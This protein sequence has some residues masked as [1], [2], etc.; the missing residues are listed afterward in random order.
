MLEHRMIQFSYL[1]SNQITC[2]RDGL[3]G[4]FSVP[5][6]HEDVLVVHFEGSLAQKTLGWA[7]DTLQRLI[8]HGW[9][10]IVVDYSRV[11]FSGSGTGSLL[12]AIKKARASGGGLLIAAPHPRIRET[13]EMLGLVAWGFVTESVDDAVKMLSRTA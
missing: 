1:R 12:S 10:R 13:L 5:L 11:T 8:E 4:R 2:G 9:T 3:A 7:L 6:E